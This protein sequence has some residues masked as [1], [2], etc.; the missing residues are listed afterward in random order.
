[1]RRTVLASI[2]TLVFSV[3]LFSQAAIISVDPPK[4]TYGPGDTFIAAIRI[5]T[6]GT[7]IN[8]AH[9]ELSYPVGIVRVVDISRGDS[10]FSLWPDEPKN[11]ADKGVIT[12]SGGIPGGYCGKISGDPGESNVLAKIV[13]TFLKA[14][15][16]SANIALLPASLVYLNDGLATKAQ[17]SLA[18]ATYA[19]GKQATLP[20]NDWLGILQSD[21]IPPEPFT[22]QVE[23][24]KGVFGG[25]YFAVFSTVDKQSGIDHYEIQENGI[26]KRISNPYKLTDQ[27]L[28]NGVL[29]KAVDK[30]GNERV[31]EFNPSA[32]PPRVES[33]DITT[34][35]S[36][37][38]L[39]L[40][41]LALKWFID[42]RKTPTVGP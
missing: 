33:A 14:D 7:C 8:A 36:I 21:T 37:I 6:E 42:R 29:L 1:M 19:L 22:V 18:G 3:P 41:A 24:T 38:A 30:A 17:L 32:T 5:D 31:G 40:F 25:S 13:F 9:V 39:I 34:L 2:A 10:I 15:P 23:S 26:W 35:L 4:G 16:T 28:K 20:S 12:F 11:D 27:S